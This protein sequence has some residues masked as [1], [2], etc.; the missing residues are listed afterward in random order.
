MLLLFLDECVKINIHKKLLK[1]NLFLGGINMDF[2]IL[3][4]LFAGFV[5]LEFFIWW[6]KSKVDTKQN[7]VLDVKYLDDSLQAFIEK[8]KKID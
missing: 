8:Q 4:V 7:K 3:A 6:L 1:I 5:F 2:I